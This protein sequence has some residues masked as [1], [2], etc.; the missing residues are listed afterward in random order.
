MSETI[1]LFCQKDPDPDKGAEKY[2][3]L[4]V[5]G[6]AL[7]DGTEIFGD[8]PSAPI[9][10]TIE[11]GWPDDQAERF[12]AYYEEHF[13]ERIA[14]FRKPWNCFT[15]STTV[16]NQDVLWLPSAVPHNLRTEREVASTK[17]ADGEPYL[18]R[19][20]KGHIVH[21]LIGLPDPSKNI[22]VYG[23]CRPLKV[24]SNLLTQRIYGPTFW[25][26]TVVPLSD[27]SMTEKIIGQLLAT[28]LFPE[29]YRQTRLALRHMF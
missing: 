28:E 25:E 10:Q 26:S 8:V 5:S 4:I 24:T 23:H 27:M 18:V 7:Q 17:L 14:H 20:K 6:V 2:N 19:D 15:F 3:P 1:Q 16:A 12:A 21:A 13:T 9:E 11:L 22:A 29:S